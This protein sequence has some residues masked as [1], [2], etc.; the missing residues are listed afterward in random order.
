MW[1]HGKEPLK[2]SP[3]PTKI[4]DYRHC[5]SENI[6]ILVYHVILQDHEINGSFDFMGKKSHLS[7]L[8]SCQF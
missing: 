6:L 4:G 7:K 5:G 1:L 3:Y 2:V 8:P